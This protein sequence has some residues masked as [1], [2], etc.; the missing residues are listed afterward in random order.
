MFDAQFWTFAGLAALLIVTPGPDTLLVLKNSISG[1]RATGLHTVWGIAVGTYVH[2]L[3]S[4][5][6]L[7]LI[8]MQSSRAFTVVKWA[9]AVYLIWLGIQSLWSGF[10]TGTEAALGESAEAGKRKF[11]RSGFVQGFMSNILNPK[12]AVFYLAVLPQFVSPGQSVLG[13]SLFLATLYVVMGIIWLSAVSA[14][15]AR[16]K[17]VFARQGLRRA[18][19]GLAGLALVGFG[20]KLATERNP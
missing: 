3:A 19:S 8:L 13:R 15:A 5:L 20:V 6:G 11:A 10:R 18:V 1:G 9:G 7:S 14:A 12:V 4:A 17:S 16:A 2:A